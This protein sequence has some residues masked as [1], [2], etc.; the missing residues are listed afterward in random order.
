MINVT[1][2]NKNNDISIMYLPDTHLCVVSNDNEI[3]QIRKYYKYHSL[4]KFVLKSN[5]LDLFK[6]AAPKRNFT[7]PN[8]PLYK[9]SFILETIYMAISP[10]SSLY[11]IDYILD[12]FENL[13]MM[14]RNF[15]KM[16]HELR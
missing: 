13:G 15:E 3:I 12:E 5:T 1:V 8:N 4:K 14:E 7:V 6:L 2:V 16:K 10:K 9:N 11:F